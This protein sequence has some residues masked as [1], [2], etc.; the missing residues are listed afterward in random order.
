MRISKEL[1]FS[2]TPKRVDPKPMSKSLLTR[3]INRTRQSMKARRCAVYTVMK[4]QLTVSLK[5]KMKIYSMR[6]S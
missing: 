6:L 1:N 5:K 3:V 4:N 2:K